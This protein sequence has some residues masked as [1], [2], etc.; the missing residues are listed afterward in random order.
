[1]VGYTATGAQVARMDMPTVEQGTTP[2]DATAVA[3]E[4]R[5]LCRHSSIPRDR[6]RRRCSPLRPCAQ[7]FSC[8]QQAPRLTTVPWTTPPPT[9][10]GTLGMLAEHTGRIHHPTG[11]T[12]EDGLI[13]TGIDTVVDGV[14]CATTKAV[15]PSAA[16]ERPM[17][18]TG[19]MTGRG[20]GT[21]GDTMMIPTTTTASVVART[22]GMRNGSGV[23]TSLHHIRRATDT[24]TGLPAMNH[25]IDTVVLVR[26]AHRRP[27]GMTTTEVGVHG[28]SSAETY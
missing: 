7:D 15:C 18:T 8:H 6:H 2:S 4:A 5:A 19:G 10:M 14:R 9:H 1:M 20:T 16:A 23:R 28:G 26:G 21:S 3:T 13:P 11:K 27:P 25:H 22:G 12:V 17:E 24:P